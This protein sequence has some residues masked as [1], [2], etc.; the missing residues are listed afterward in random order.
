MKSVVTWTRQAMKRS[1]FIILIITLV[2]LDIVLTIEEE[3][4]SKPFV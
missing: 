3:W 2:D 1:N 4:G